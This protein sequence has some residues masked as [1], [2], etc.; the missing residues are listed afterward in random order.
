L[1]F[2]IERKKADDLASSIIDGRYKDQ[3]YRLK[4]CGMQNVFYLFEGHITNL[5][6]KNPKELE[7]ALL[8]TRVMDKFKIIQTQNIN[9][10]LNF[11][12]Y[13]HKEI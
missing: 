9:E 2:I 13:M 6:I 1:D 7:N 5:S 3:K 8:K 12:V 4:N 10:S 11:L